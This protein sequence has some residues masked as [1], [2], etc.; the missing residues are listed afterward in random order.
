MGPWGL[1]VRE[2]PNE[3]GCAPSREFAVPLGSS[4]WGL[5][6]HLAT[7]GLYVRAGIVIIL[8][9]SRR[10]IMS[11]ADPSLPSAG[12]T[13]GNQEMTARTNPRDVA[14]GLH[15]ILFPCTTAACQSPVAG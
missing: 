7:L 15:G 3:Q 1:F 8:Q 12:L 6:R 11:C 13:C 10:P 14:Y 9:E 4:A 2:S 5:T